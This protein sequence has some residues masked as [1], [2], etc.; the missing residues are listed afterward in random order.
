[1]RNRQKQRELRR[2]GIRREQTI[3]WRN[4]EYYNDPTPREAVREIV[5]ERRRRNG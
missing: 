2:A 4:A 5:K 3:G 1:M